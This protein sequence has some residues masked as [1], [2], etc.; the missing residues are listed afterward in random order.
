VQLLKNFPTFYGTRRFITCSQES[1]T[2]PYPEPDQSNLQHPILSI[3][4]ILCTHLRLGLP[5]GLF[6]SG[7]PTNILYAVFFSPSCYMPCPSHPPSLDHS[8]YTWRRVQVMKLLSM[9]LSP[10]FRHSSPFGPNI[11]LST[12]FSNTLTVCSS[13]NV[14]DQISH[15]YRTTRKIIV[16]Y[17]LISLG[18]SYAN[19]SKYA[20]CVLWRIWCFL[21]NDFPKY[22]VHQMWSLLLNGYSTVLNC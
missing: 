10:T 17:I 18:V 2:G 16:L 13:L 4:L 3:I 5:S 6:P 22:A 9:Q 11:L 12:L 7:I 1:F 8:D 21:R 14:R 19:I 20:R 15:P